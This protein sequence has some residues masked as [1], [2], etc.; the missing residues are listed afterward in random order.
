LRVRVRASEKGRVRKTA[1]ERVRFVL[2][3]A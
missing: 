2:T 3:S 1:S